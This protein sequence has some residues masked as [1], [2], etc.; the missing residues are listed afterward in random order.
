[1]W[2]SDFQVLGAPASMDLWGTNWPL[3]FPTNFPKLLV[4]EIH[5]FFTVREEANIFSQKQKIYRYKN[6]FT[7]FSIC[8]L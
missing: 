5:S 2:A 3:L 6:L 8:F 7:N 1:M 4:V